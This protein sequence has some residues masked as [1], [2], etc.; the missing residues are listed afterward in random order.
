MLVHAGRA[1]IDYVFQKTQRLLNAVERP[2]GT[3]ST[4]NKLWHG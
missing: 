4:D 3:S 1:R 2:V